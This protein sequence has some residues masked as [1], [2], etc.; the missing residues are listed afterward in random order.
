MQAGIVQFGMPKKG[1]FREDPTNDQ[2]GV[3]SKNSS[4]LLWEFNQQFLQDF[5]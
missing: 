1:P 5:F 4:R 3:P 2:T